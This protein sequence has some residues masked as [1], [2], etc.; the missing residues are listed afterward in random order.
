M[1]LLPLAGK[2]MKTQITVDRTKNTLFN[3][4]SHTYSRYVA[5]IDEVVV[6]GTEAFVGSAWWHHGRPMEN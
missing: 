4:R 3:A 5:L 1:V 6:K 2:L